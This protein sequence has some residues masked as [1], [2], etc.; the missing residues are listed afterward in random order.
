MTA[1]ST[2]TATPNPIPILSP[3]DNP[4]EALLGVGFDG[5]PV[6]DEIEVED[7][8]ENALALGVVR[9]SEVKKMKHLT[10]KLLW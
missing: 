10:L 3:D 9:Y 8:L 2:I 6:A 7:M 1:M 5:V 4:D